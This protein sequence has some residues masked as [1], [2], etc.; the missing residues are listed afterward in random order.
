MA[1]NQEQFFAQDT[2]ELSVAEQISAQ[3][4][5]NAGE[6]TPLFPD[7]DNDAEVRTERRSNQKSKS[8][9]FPKPLIFVIAGA[10]LFIIFLVLVALFS[11]GNNKNSAAQDALQHQTDNQ[12]VIEISSLR[13]QFNYLR[14]D[15]DKLKI[16][17]KKSFEDVESRIEATDLK[18]FNDRLIAIED[19]LD[20]NADAITKVA[21]TQQNSRPLSD[22]MQINHSAK[23][24]TISN[25]KARVVDLNGKE[26]NLQKGDKWDGSVVT[27]IRADIRK[28]VLSNG[29]M[30]E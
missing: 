3:D 19:N 11:G 25:G 7:S 2:D 30:L 18:K 23:V 22:L 8:N 4:S 10:I 16:D 13:E 9:G 20:A 24:L 14:N 1:N 29:S 6:K 12:L 26:T 27:A 5:S 15:V 17:M 28:V 21:K